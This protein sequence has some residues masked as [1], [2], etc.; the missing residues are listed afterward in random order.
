MKLI[1]TLEPDPTVNAPVVIVDA[2]V[3][4]VVSKVTLEALAPVFATKA[5][6]PD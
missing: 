3:P 5:M 4:E 1:P 2:F 6:A